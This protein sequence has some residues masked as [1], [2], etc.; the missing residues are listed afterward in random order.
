MQKFEAFFVTKEALCKLWSLVLVVCKSLCSIGTP[1]VGRQEMENKVKYT[2]K[3]G[4]NIKRLTD[5][6]E[7]QH[8]G[9]YQHLLS[10]PLQM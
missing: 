3:D 10:S 8:T 9:F 7:K 1:K 4:Q 6:F 5:L 2:H